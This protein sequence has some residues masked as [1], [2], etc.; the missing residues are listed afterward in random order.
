MTAVRRSLVFS[1]QIFGLQ[2]GFLAPNNLITFFI[3]TTFLQLPALGICIGTFLQMYI[4]KNWKN[5]DSLI[6][7]SLPLSHFHL[8][9]LLE[10]FHSSY[11]PR[12]SSTLHLP[13]PFSYS[14]LSLTYCLKHQKNEIIRGRRDAGA[15]QFSTNFV[16]NVLYLPLN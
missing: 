3:F 12:R 8:S 13:N 11:L 2:S 1:L 7:E 9:I 15:D 14:L 6:C 5:D 16:F 4:C 10:F